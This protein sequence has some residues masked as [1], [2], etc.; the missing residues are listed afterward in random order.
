MVIRSFFVRNEMQF[1]L[2]R[3]IDDRMPR[4]SGKSVK[5]R[6]RSVTRTQSTENLDHTSYHILGYECRPLIG[7]EIKKNPITET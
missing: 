6:Q 2:R 7:N 3:L 4:I 5:H 1:I